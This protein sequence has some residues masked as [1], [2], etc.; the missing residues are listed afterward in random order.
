NRL[1][2]ATRTGTYPFSQSYGYDLNNNRTSITKDGTATSATYD[3]ANQMTSLGGTGYSYDRNGNLTAFG[4][5][6]LNYD[7][8]NKWVSGTVNGNDVTFGYDGFGRRSSRTVGTGRIDYWYD[9]TGL[10]LQTGATN[11]TFLRDQSGSV[12]SIT[13]GGATHNYGKDRL[14]SVTAMVATD[15]TVARTYSYDPWGETIGITG[16]AYN[17]FLFTGT[18]KDGA[19]GLYQMGA[20][21]Y[22]SASGRFTQQDPLPDSILSF[23]RYAY[24]NCNPANGIDPTGLLTAECQAAVVDLIGLFAGTVAGGLGKYLV[25]ALIS[26]FFSV[27]S[28]AVAGAQNQGSDPLGAALNLLN[29]LVS[30]LTLIPGIGQGVTLV[31]GLVSSGYSLGLCVASL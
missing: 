12:R 6:S 24:A 19:T 27:L 18:Y 15:G 21:Y 5:N 20:R 22:Q 30:P 17:P 4:S 29:V 31:V 13:S 10:T 9:V 23:N 28:V 1:S 7:E 26:Q 2:G 11:A 25:E 14:G 8:S 3:A 16:T